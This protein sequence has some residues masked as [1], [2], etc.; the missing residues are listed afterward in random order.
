MVPTD[1]I[2]YFSTSAS[3]AAALIG[4]LFVATSLAPEST[5]ARSAPL[6]RRAIAVGAFTGLL[7]AFFISLSALV[8]RVEFSGPLL[9]IAISSLISTFISMGLLLRRRQSSSPLRHLFIPLAGFVIYGLEIGLC[10]LPLMQTPTSVTPFIWLAF[11]LFAVYGL[12]LAR[13]W[14]LMAGVPAV[15]A[16]RARAAQEVEKVSAGASS[17]EKSLPEAAPAIIKSAEGPAT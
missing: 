6:E 1:F 16:A 3:A 8:P 7:N 5:L 14:Q 15:I 11:L 4:L 17:A 9:G 13:A 10:A 12:A 2:P